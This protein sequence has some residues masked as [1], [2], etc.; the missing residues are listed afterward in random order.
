MER[1]ARKSSIASPEPKVK[2][3]CPACGAEFERYASQV[4]W[5][6]ARCCSVACL[7]ATNRA[8]PRICVNCGETF[9][10]KNDGT[11]G[12]GK[13][14]SRP[15][16]FA[17]QKAMRPRSRIIACAT[18]GREF[19]IFD[20]WTRK[21]KNHYCSRAC[22]GAARM[23]PGSG[24]SRGAGWTKIR[25]AIR[26]RDGHR[27]VRCGSAEIIGK[28]LAVDHIIPWVLVNTD[29]TIANH[30]DNL[31]S[32]CM[33]CHG[34]KTASIEPRMMK[35]DYISLVEFFGR[36]RAHAAM[37]NWSRLPSGLPTKIVQ[38]RMKE[39]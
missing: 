20:A 16:F 5:R 32:L 10:P 12:T 13:F 8:K 34:V 18:C 21:A 33:G 26:N 29:E 1:P 22:H 6:G 3:I 28:Q 14:C 11:I 4:R 23:R 25:I 9:Q 38:H 19:K 37:V 17:H 39:K 27:C 15:C 31:A 30:D 7:A 24:S 2:M 35:G 36:E